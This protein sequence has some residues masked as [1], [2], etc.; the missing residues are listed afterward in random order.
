[1]WT[2]REATSVVILVVFFCSPVATVVGQ[3]TNFSFSPWAASPADQS[4]GNFLASGDAQIGAQNLTMNWQ[5]ATS[6]GQIANGDCG[7][8]VF[9]QPIHMVDKASATAAS[10]NTSFTF[11]YTTL[12]NNSAMCGSGMLF[13]FSVNSN[14]TASETTLAGGSL[15]ELNYT[16]P[17]LRIFAVEFD[18]Y[19]NSDMPGDISDSHISV[20]YEDKILGNVYNLCSNSTN[21][22][23]C[24]FFCKDA[25]AKYTA[26]IDYDSGTQMLEVRFSN[27]SLPSV[28]KPADAGIRISNLRLDEIL[29]EEMFVG[30][31]GS[32]GGAREIHS[33][34][35]WE[36][37]SSL[38]VM[39]SSSS[40]HGL[41]PGLIAVDVVAAIVGTVLVASLLCFVRRRQTFKRLPLP[42]SYEVDDDDT[43]RSY[44][45]QE[46]RSM[47]KNFSQSE[48]LSSGGFGDVYKGTLANGVLLAVKRI[49]ENK[50]QAG[51]DSFLAEVRTLR[52]TRHRNLLQLRGWSNSANG[53]FLVYDFMCN[54]S[55]D[56]KIHGPKRSS[57]YRTNE[58]QENGHTSL[59]A[60]SL[61]WDQ[62]QSILA[63]VA[64]GLEYL[65]EDGMKCVLHR[66]IKSSN[67]MLDK[68]FRPYLGDFGLA[69]LVDHNKMQ[70]TT[71]PAGT[72]GYMAP[73]MIQ[74]TQA[75][76]ETDVYAFGIL[77][78]EVA[79]G[80]RPVETIESS[81]DAPPLMLLE[82]VW[83]AHEGGNILQAADATLIQEPDATTTSFQRR[84]TADSEDNEM[85]D[86]LL[87]DGVKETMADVLRMGLLCCLPTPS[88]RPSMRVVNQWFQSLEEGLTVE[89]PPLPSSKPPMPVLG[90]SSS[91]VSSSSNASLTVSILVGR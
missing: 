69:R 79:C 87:A 20:D 72:W 83:R 57:N 6:G 82:H 15:C 53:M 67:V 56:K 26:W 13:M 51:E 80:K 10:F 70:K 64:S 71:T 65:H 84:D 74:S 62:R 47:T 12:R 59:E 8:V 85:L 41:S 24:A 25:N 23:R 35:A 78:L 28:A 55:L 61:S 11:S 42:G 1:M 58:F 4:A 18:S 81:E 39:N 48:L 75:S 88:D 66:D 34:W 17:N 89:L 9:K 14:V 46:L 22:T 36:F 54:G 5:D 60:G 91:N 31:I 27:G 49:K 21:T 45:Y 19:L 68:D 90:Q 76:K 37:A 77:A 50:E 2:R 7:R 30:F 3:N 52:Q 63:G 29:D 32:T 40:S 73:E 43:S 33:I 16:N 38:M 86:L 44:T